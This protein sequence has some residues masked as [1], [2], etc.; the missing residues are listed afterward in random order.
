MACKI[1]ERI[2]R[3]NNLRD[4]KTVSLLS[5]AEQLVTGMTDHGETVD[6]AY[7]ELTKN[8]HLVCHRLL[9]KKDASFGD[10]PLDNSLGGGR[11]NF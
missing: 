11:R 4:L 7:L 1:L 2:V 5:D 10:P 3:T 9:I 6:V 8:F